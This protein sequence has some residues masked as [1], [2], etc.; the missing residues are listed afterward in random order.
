MKI[1]HNIKQLGT[2][3][4]FSVLAEAQELIDKGQDILNL[5][6]GTPDF[7][8][9]ENIIE[10]AHKAIDDG[11]H[12][13][14]AVKG[15]EPLR[16]AIA[17]DIQ[18]RRSAQVD[19]ENILVTP[20]AKPSINFAL[21]MFGEPGAEIL[22]PD[23]GFPI[24][25]SMIE[26]TGAKPIAI[27]H[28]SSDGFQFDPAEV[29]S[30]LTPDTRLLILNYPSNPTGAA[31]D[32]ERMDLL[33]EGLLDYPNVYIL[34]DEIYARINYE[35][36]HV[37]PYDYEALR[38]RI[39]LVDGWSKTYAMTGWRLGYSIWP[40][41][42]IDFAERLQINDSSCASAIV[43]MAG[44]EALTGPQDGAQKMQSIFQSRR[45]LIIELLN[46]IEG[47]SCAAPAGAF[48]AFAD[49][50]DTKMCS[51][52]LQSKL[53]HK[54]GVACLSGAS[55]GDYGEGFLRFSYAADHTIIK[56]AMSRF[57]AMV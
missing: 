49:I 3:S 17:A 22:Y 56:A 14:T 20:G 24:Y 13:Y 53:L 34:S 38:D 48:Y 23:P 29:L 8:T 2:E 27:P 6:I 21:Q 35:H 10:A 36:Q 1:S 57:K 25:K 51:D 26:F 43:Q 41:Q 18:K 31:I 55:F 46:E 16:I 9:P 15:L 52:E 40:S 11:Y 5:A 4:A 7:K 32:R 33:A 45:D 30:L 39:I 54:A 37:S 28:R 50:T 42:L 44:L 47:V 19:I 12:Y